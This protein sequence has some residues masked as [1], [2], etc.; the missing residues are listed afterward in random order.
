MYS[1]KRPAQ[2]SAS[3]MSRTPARKRTYR[4]QGG[5]VPSYHGYNPRGFVHGEWKYV[6]NVFTDAISTTT[7]MT[8]CDALA[9]GTAANQRIGMKVAIRS[10]ELRVWL[11]NNAATGVEQAVRVMLFW[12]RQANGAI[13][14]AVTDIIIAASPIAPRNLANRRRFKIIKDKVFTIGSCAA[15][16]GSPTSRTYKNYIKFKKPVIVEYNAGVAGNIADISSNSLYMLTIG[17]EADG[18]TCCGCN[19]VIR[20]RYTDM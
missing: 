19:A 12:D 11:M 18:D 6:D 5:L 17:T 2:M 13:P 3:Y 9:P 8:L 16:T 7:T 15:T 14:A 10:I 4:R 1:R 20:V